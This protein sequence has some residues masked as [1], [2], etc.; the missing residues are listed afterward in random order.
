MSIT[1]MLTYLLICWPPFPDDLSN[2][3]RAMFLGI[4]SFLRLAAHCR[5][6]AYSTS[7]SL[8]AEDKPLEIFRIPT[9]AEQFRENNELKC[10]E[11]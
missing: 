5:A 10:F 9:T 6:A 8:W 11:T 1:N 2:R 4:V 7:R 3:T